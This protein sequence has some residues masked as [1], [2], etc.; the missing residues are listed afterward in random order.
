MLAIIAGVAAVTAV[1]QRNNAIYERDTALSRQLSAQART[2]VVGEL[3]RSLLLSLESGYLRSTPEARG[4]LLTALQRTPGLLQDIETGHNLAVPSITAV[5]WSPSGREL[6]LSQANGDIVRWDVERSA[7]I[8]PVLS[9]HSAAVFA[10][11]YSHSGSLIASAGSDGNIRLWDLEA[12]DP[13][14]SRVIEHG[15]TVNTVSFGSDDETIVSAGDDRA[16]L[17]SVASLQPVGPSMPGNAAVFNPMDGNTVAVA[18]RN[19]VSLWDVAHG[20]RTATAASSVPDAIQDLVFD[21]A[22][23]TLAS[24]STDGLAVLW[25]VTKLQPRGEPLNGYKSP[26]QG[27]RMPS[28]SD[29]P[30]RNLGPGDRDRHVITFSNDGSMLASG[31]IDDSVVLWDVKSGQMLGYYPTTFQERVYGIAFRPDDDRIATATSR[32]DVLVWNNGRS[33]GINKTIGRHQDWALAVAVGP[34]GRTVTSGDRSGAIVVWDAVEQKQI[35]ASMAQPGDN[36]GVA[37]LSLS[38]DGRLLASSGGRVVLWDMATHQ[39]IA[40]LAESSP[41]AGVAFSPTGS[42]LAASEG[43]TVVLWD[44]AS[45]SIVRRLSGHATDVVF[46]GFSA[47]GRILATSSTDGRVVLWDPATGQ[48]TG[49]IVATLG[50]HSLAV[51]PDGTTI[52]TGGGVA[53]GDVTLWDPRTGGISTVFTG[54]SDEVVGLAFSPDGTTLASVSSDGSMILWDL[55]S[56]EQLGPPLRG[57]RSTIGPTFLD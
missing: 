14:K 44:T 41:K 26:H 6:A 11:A 54:H 56:R 29:F 36:I 52:A 55:A 47:D 42:T 34:D 30:Y 45:R 31:G 38:P 4:A 23:N 13:A 39:Q 32:G 20:Q 7:R 40:I 37:A 15:K 12:A 33:I 18:F 8:D 35:G 1:L 21:P 57:H 5:A 43:Q 10:L 16:Q 50:V 49:E 28:Q 22:G 9:G 3:P 48:K 27:D 24:S 53:Q 2:D 19:E 17:W 25:D 51:S 46:V